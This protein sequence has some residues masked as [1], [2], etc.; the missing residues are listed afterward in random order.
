MS[1]HPI[2]SEAPAP[3]APIRH[4]RTRKLVLPTLQLRLVV[5]LTVMVTAALLLQSFLI[6]NGFQ[7]ELARLRESGEDVL[8]ALPTVMREALV[9][10]LGMLVPVVFGMG[11][12]LTFRIAGPAFRM[13]RWLRAIA[14]GEEPERIRLRAGDHL[15]SLC[16]ALNEAVDALRAR[17]AADVGSSRTNDVDRAA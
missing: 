11:I 8:G 13:E 12:L 15:G 1:N 6:V 7:R 14:R 10:A 16:D 4:R 17:R 9:F 5:L 3:P 2:R